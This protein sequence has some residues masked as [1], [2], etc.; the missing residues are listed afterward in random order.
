MNVSTIAR[1]LPFKKLLQKAS[2]FILCIYHL[3]LLFKQVKQ[4]YFSG[5]SLPLGGLN[6]TKSALL[7]H[8][9]PHPPKIC[10]LKM[11]LKVR[12]GGLWAGGGILYSWQFSRNGRNWVLMVIWSKIFNIFQFET[13]SKRKTLDC[14]NIFQKSIVI[15]EYFSKKIRCH[16]NQ[17]LANF[18]KFFLKNAMRHSW[19]EYHKTTHGRGPLKNISEV[20]QRCAEGIM[21]ISIL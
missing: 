12:F 11:L 9:T 13:I 5:E 1:I 6:N 14:W 18:R 21:K 3:E 8:K 4:R 10:F 17:H 2:K 19:L 15:L 20:I 7:N 16:K